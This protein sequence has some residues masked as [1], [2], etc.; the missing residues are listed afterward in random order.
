MRPRQSL[1]ALAQ[2]MNCAIHNNCMLAA[3]SAAAGPRVVQMRREAIPAELLL[4]KEDASKL[5]A[6]VV[7]TRE[8]L[9]QAQRDVNWAGKREQ[10]FAA[11]AAG[12]HLATFA[13]N[14]AFWGVEGMPPDRY[15]PT[16]PR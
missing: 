11:V 1:L 13:L 3:S 7:Q 16:S 4:V 14:L 9:K 2:I 5:P 12:W 15:W 10:V 6:G 8:Q